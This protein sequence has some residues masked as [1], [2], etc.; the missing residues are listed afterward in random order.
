MMLSTMQ[1]INKTVISI[2]AVYLGEG[3]RGKGWRG[4]GGKGGR[5]EGGKGGRG[6][7]GWHSL[8]KVTGGPTLGS[9]PRVAL[10]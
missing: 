7:G 5:G 3:G 9:L 2:A 1:I 8:I 6:E 4:E 10:Q